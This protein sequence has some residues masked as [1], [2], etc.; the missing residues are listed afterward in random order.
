MIGAERWRRGED[1]RRQEEEYQLVSWVGRDQVHALQV[2]G[3]VEQRL[4]GGAQDLIT[5]GHQ[6][7]ALR[8]KTH[9]E[10]GGCEASRTK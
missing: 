9:R 8:E 6:P 5:D 4:R 1:E 3:V 10:P 7:P 2:G